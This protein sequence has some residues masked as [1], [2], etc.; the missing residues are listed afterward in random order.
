VMKVGS[1]VVAE[2][3]SLERND[4]AKILELY[5]TTVRNGEGLP[6]GVFEGSIPRKNWLI[7]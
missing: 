1:W 3:N 4:Y 7:I 6:P 5:W 2:L